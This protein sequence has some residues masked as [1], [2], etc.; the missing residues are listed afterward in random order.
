MK[1]FEYLKKL[2]E[3]KSDQSSKRFIALIIS[4]LIIYITIIY[5]TEQNVV[6]ILIELIS[7]VLVLMGVAVWENIKK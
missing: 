5:A 3:K 4:C 7:F 1:I 6:L 2:I